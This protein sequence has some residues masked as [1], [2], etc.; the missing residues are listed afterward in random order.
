MTLIGKDNQ[1]VQ[2]TRVA[3]VKLPTQPVTSQLRV[4]RVTGEN[5]SSLTFSLF[6]QKVNFSTQE[7]GQF[8]IV[9]GAKAAESESSSESESTNESSDSTSVSVSKTTDVE[10]NLPNTGEIKNLW[11]ITLGILLALLGVL[12]VI[13]NRKVE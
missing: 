11:Y 3:Q 10:Q 5:T 9:Y 6:N 4:L 2:L 8:A 7:L 12:L 1:P 13:R